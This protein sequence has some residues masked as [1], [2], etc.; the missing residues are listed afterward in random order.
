MEMKYSANS[1][2]YNYHMA[3]D[4]TLHKY[5]KYLMKR[6]HKLLFYFKQGNSAAKI[7]K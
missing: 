2:D 7:S 3:D 5:A 6:I 4:I 1:L